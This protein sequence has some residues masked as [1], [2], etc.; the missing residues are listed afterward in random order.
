M[1]G[2]AHWGTSPDH[3]LAKAKQAAREAIKKGSP[4]GLTTLERGFYDAMTR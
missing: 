1:A 2:P 3:V 4:K